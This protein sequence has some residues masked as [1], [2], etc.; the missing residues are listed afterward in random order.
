MKTPMVKLNDG[1]EMPQLGLGVWQSTGGAEVDA[2]RWALEA[3]YRHIDTAAIYKN[4]EGVGRALAESEVARD[5]I[6]LTTKLWNADIRAGHARR[7]LETSLR[8]LG[9]DHIDLYLLHWPTQ[10]FEQA[11]TQLVALREEG[12]CRS[13][14]V[15]NF[16][17]EHLEAIAADAVPAVNQVEL[18]PYFQPA[19]VL[20]ACEARGIAIEGWSPLMQGEFR[21]E[22]LFSTIGEA[23][24]KSAAQVVLRWALQRGFITI[25]KSKNESRI[26]ENGDVFDF[27]LSDDQMAQVDAL[28]RDGR[29]GPDPRNFSF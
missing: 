10:G 20:Q 18:H 26:R 28:G 22:P 11:W 17:P 5:D 2:V 8:K 23:L 16:M 27:A 9:L 7:G 3:G 15:S 14:G 13:I 19:E 12:L 24:G 29:L 1:R 25:P 4:E 6:W 21:N